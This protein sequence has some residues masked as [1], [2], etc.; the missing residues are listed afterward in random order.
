[1]S[2]TIAAG[3]WVTLRYRIRDAQGEPIEAGERELTY[4]HGGYGAV[5]PGIEQALEGY[6]AGHAATVD[7]EPEDAFGDYDASLVH[8]A[9]RAGF[10]DD[11]EAGMG[12]QKVPGMPELDGD[13]NVYI[14]TEFTDDTVVLDGNHPLAGMALRFELT[15]MSVAQATDEDIE[16]ER[17]L[18]EDDAA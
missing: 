3:R 7:L 13:G 14:A 8:L 16:R 6:G 12:F 9:P 18:A 1:M 11:L 2:M 5:L 17:L 4:L 10:P 15:V